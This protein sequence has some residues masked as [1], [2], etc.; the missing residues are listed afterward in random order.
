MAPFGMKWNELPKHTSLEQLGFSIQDIKVWRELEF[1][2][3]RASGLDDFFTAHGLCAACRCI[4]ARI[5]GWDEQ[6]DVPLWEICPVCA[7]TGKPKS[8]S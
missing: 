5:V 8:D 4:G 2:A 1:Q 3:G 7:G 6:S